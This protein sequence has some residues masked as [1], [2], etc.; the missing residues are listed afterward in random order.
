[1]ALC[2]AAVNGLRSQQQMSCDA[3]SSFP[4][5][6]SS[7]PGL[8]NLPAI[9]QNMTFMAGYMHGC[10]ALK[11]YYRSESAQVENNCTP[12]TGSMQRQVVDIKHEVFGLEV[13]KKGWTKGR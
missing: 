10:N 8:C 11:R 6:H 5:W 2:N 7:T 12:T 3:V 1:M 13:W 9:G 4:P